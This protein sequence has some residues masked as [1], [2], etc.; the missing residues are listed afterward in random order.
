M[1]KSF[2]RAIV[3]SSV[4]KSRCI[5]F[6][7]LLNN[8]IGAAYIQICILLAGKGCVRQVFSGSTGAN[9][10]ERILFAYFLTQLFIPFSNRFGQFRRHR[11]G[12]DGFTNLSCY[13]TKLHGIFDIRQFFKHFFNLF[14]KT[15]FGHEIS[16]S[17][18]CRSKTV[19]Y[20]HVCSR[21][22]FT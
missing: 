13:Y 16:I 6:F 20:R 4:R 7:Y 9:S 5:T 12:T 11:S 18:R 17:C 15:C 2:F 1:V 21:R 19:R 3:C 10:H 22:Q 8:H 14:I